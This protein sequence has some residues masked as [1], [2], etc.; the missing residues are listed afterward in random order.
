MWRSGCLAVALALLLAASALALTHGGSVALRTLLL[1]PDLFPSSPVRPLTLATPNP[2]RDTVAFDYPGG[3]VEADVYRPAAEGRHGG[4]VL[5][6]GVKP[7]P[8]RHPALVRFADG[9]ARAGA[10]VMIPE[11]TNLD[12]GRLDPAVEQGIEQSF[13]YLRQQPYVD[14]ARLGFVGFSVGGSLE[15]VTLE[16]A[17]LRDLAGF[18]NTFGSYYDAEAFLIDVVS[19]SIEVDGHQERWEA[20][21]LTRSVLALQVI[22]SLPDPGDR[23]AL[24]AAFLEGSS[25]ERLDL[26]TLSPAG[27]AAARLL[28]RVPR[29]EVGRLV[30]ALP[31][32]L[33]A[34]LRAISPSSN[35]AALR[36]RLYVMHDVGDHYIP[37]TQSRELAAA[38]PPGTLVRSTEFNLFSHVLPDRPVPL[39]TLA[40]QAALLYRHV[41]SV[42]LEFL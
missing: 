40:E 22:E 38:A 30:D 16:H 33:R 24:S 17:P 39:P 32:A 29:D 9:M 18:V 13:L 42:A 28:L 3:H 15:L 31:L 8:K 34:R 25:P 21:P 20:D 19:S 23:A 4:F 6:L 35:I 7:F 1:L 5:L 10:V 12:A 14:A 27:A 2:I 37:Y 11:D 26:G 36:A 41:Y